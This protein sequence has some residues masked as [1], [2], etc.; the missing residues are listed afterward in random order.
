MGSRKETER[1]TRA[2]PAGS[3]KSLK[4][5]A[6][7]RCPFRGEGGTATLETLRTVRPAF[8]RFAE[9]RNP[10][11]R[12]D[13]IV[14]GPG[15]ARSLLWFVFSEVQGRRGLDNVT[16]ALTMDATLAL[17]VRQG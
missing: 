9:S 11:S 12:M 4:R 3:T 1:R 17:I 5:T 8:G 16:E 14:N 2:A 6:P 15:L 7:S 10:C 13:R